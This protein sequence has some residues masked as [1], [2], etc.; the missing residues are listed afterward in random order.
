[1]SKRNKLFNHIIDRVEL[2]HESDGED[3]KVLANLSSLIEYIWQ[4]ENEYI[5]TAKQSREFKFKKVRVQVFY[6]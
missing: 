2:L 5:K 6:E 1:M 4:G 3:L